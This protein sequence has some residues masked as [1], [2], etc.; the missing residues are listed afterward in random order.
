MSSVLRDDDHLSRVRA[1]KQNTL[2]HCASISQPGTCIFSNQQQN[3]SFRIQG[4]KL[5]R[6]NHFKGHNGTFLMVIS[7]YIATVTLTTMKK[8]MEATEASKKACSTFKSG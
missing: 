6:K 3:L 4:Q 1:T 8:K 5:V 2:T 7:I